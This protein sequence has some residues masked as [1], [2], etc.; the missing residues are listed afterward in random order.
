MFFSVTLHLSAVVLFKVLGL[1]IDLKFCRFCLRFE[2]V[3]ED[4]LLHVFVFVVDV[5]GKT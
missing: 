3:F 5:V 1:Y 4:P 2:N